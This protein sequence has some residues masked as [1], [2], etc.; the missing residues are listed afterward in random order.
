VPAIGAVEHGS[1]LLIFI[2][3]SP[4]SKRYIALYVWLHVAFDSNT[5]STRATQVGELGY[6]QPSPIQQQ[7]IPPALAGRDIHASAVT[8]SGKTAAFSLPFLERL[9]Y[10]SKR[11]PTI[12][13]CV[14]QSKQLNIVLVVKVVRVVLTSSA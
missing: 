4:C 3:R 10:R 14:H 5:L 8:G 6:Q 1:R 12:R 9:L 7:A 11:L 13:V 2:Y